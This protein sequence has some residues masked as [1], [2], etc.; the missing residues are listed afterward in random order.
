M[1]PPPFVIMTLCMCVC[2][3]KVLL[4]HNDSLALR[5][6]GMWLEVWSGLSRAVLMCILYVP[7]HVRAR[8]HV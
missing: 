5:L 1:L 7:T 3:L 8:V 4:L 2:V 6:V